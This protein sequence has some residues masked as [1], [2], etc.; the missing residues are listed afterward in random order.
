MSVSERT[1]WAFIRNRKLGFV[2]RTQHPV[3]D[4]VLDFYCPEAKLCI[5]VDGEQHELTRE[6]DAYRDKE[7]AG[8]GIYTLRIPSLDLFTSTGSD[9]SKWIR[10]IV[11]L[12]EVRAERVVWPNGIDI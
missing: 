6:R 5:E 12:C 9:F 7:L 8:L 1:L 3:G 2:F 11:R 10:E 4:W